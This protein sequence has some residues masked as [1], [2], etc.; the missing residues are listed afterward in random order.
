MY[1]FNTIQ[2]ASTVIEEFNHMIDLPDEIQIIPVEINILTPYFTVI[3]QQLCLVTVPFN[4]FNCYQ[5]YFQVIEKRL[6]PSSVL[7]DLISRKYQGSVLDLFAGFGRDSFIF[8]YRGC[9]VTAV[10]NNPYIFVVLS[11][12]NKLYYKNFS[13]KLELKYMDAYSFIKNDESETI[14]KKF[15]TVYIDPMFDDNQ[16]ALPPKD[17]QI[18]AYLSSLFNNTAIEVQELSLALLKHLV[19]NRVIIKRDNKQQ[20]LLYDAKPNFAKKSKC[21]RFD[22]YTCS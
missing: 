19:A 21:I 3:D 5:Y 2:V 17:M 9:K 11:Y 6:K 14:G 7:H 20:A 16:S 10:E 13:R 8:L 4:I 18:I 12:F 1:Q 22:V 15:E